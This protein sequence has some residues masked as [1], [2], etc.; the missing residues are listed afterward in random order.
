MHCNS[1]KNE[2]VSRNYSK[3]ACA[4]TWKTSSDVNWSTDQL[5]VSI[6]QFIQTK[7]NNILVIDETNDLIQ[8]KKRGVLKQMHEG[9]DHGRQARRAKNV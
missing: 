6:I 5:Q 1:N 8:H 2:Y 3:E 9:G 7:K 4:E